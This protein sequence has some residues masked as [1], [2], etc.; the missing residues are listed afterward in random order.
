[1]IGGVRH[2]RDA[3]QE[4]ADQKQRR[5]HKARTAPREHEMP[6]KRPNPWAA[7]KNAEYK[8]LPV[9][10]KIVFCGGIP[11][12]AAP[13]TGHPPKIENRRGKIRREEQHPADDDGQQRQNMANRGGRL[14]KDAFERILFQ[15]QQNPVIQAPCH[16]CPRRAVPQAGQDP[17]NQQVAD[18]L[19]R[20]YTAAAKRDI[21]I[22]TEPA[23][24]GNVPSAP[25]LRQ[26][27]REVGMVEVGVK[28]E[29]EQLRHADGHVGIAAEVEVEL[30]RI[31][32][33][34]EPRRPAGKRTG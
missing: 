2:I 12:R 19:W 31:A 11:K 13:G 25:E 1:M 24:K 6:V 33:R 10:C 18:A 3:K 32:D 16:E 21:H 30:K 17:D 8:K 9:C 20:A 23:A 34:A 26:G 7:A 14:C 22:V 5:K 28:V 15:Q 4:N 29:A 27:S